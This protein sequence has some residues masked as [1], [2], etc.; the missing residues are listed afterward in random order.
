MPGD[1]RKAVLELLKQQRDWYREA[2]ETLASGQD[3]LIE[4]APAVSNGPEVADS[5][6]A[7]AG[8][9]LSL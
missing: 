2:I 3:V 6:L 8:V 5:L 7:M 1:A 9:G 4:G